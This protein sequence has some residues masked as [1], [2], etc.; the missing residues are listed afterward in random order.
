MEYMSL[1]IMISGTFWFASITMLNAKII[2]P[3]RTPHR[4]ISLQAF[5]VYRNRIKAESN[6]VKKHRLKLLYGLLV[7]FTA[8]FFFQI[9]LHLETV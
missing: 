7:F 8:N 4:L 1:F 3:P 6:S 2:D 5:S 9:V